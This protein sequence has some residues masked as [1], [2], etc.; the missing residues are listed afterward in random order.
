[1]TLDPALT[2]GA[3]GVVTGTAGATARWVVKMS[4]DYARFVTCYLMFILLGGGG[5]GGGGGMG[6]A[7]GA[8]ARLCGCPRWADFV[9]GL[10]GASAVI[11]FDAAMQKLL[12]K[13]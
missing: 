12:R 8:M 9:S 13:P 2:V 6:I 5:G 11:C 4:R 10:L 7:G 1:M 3:V